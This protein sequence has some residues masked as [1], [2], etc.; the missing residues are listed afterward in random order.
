[1]KLN[2][3]AIDFSEKLVVFIYNKN[4]HVF[5]ERNTKREEKSL[6][7]KNILE[8]FMKGLLDNRK[9]IIDF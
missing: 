6:L 3:P 9:A 2:V 1:M 5:L 4:L 8:A 7:K